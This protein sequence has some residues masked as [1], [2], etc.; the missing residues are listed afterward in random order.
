M[1]QRPFVLLTLLAL[2]CVASQAQTVWRCGPDGRRYADSPCEQGRPIE[3]AQGRPAA[4]L[5]QAQSMV[6]REQ[7]LS[8]QLARERQQREA[9]ALSAP[10]GIRGS[11]LAAVP[12]TSRAK[13][14]GRGKHRLEAPGAWRATGPASRRGPD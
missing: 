1:K 13:A 8:A 2:L 6:R 4:D 14:P 10:A 3:V 9:L 12:V 5:Q 11:R 7:A